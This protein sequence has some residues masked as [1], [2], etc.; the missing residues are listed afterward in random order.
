MS[1]VLR[2]GRGRRGRS[3]VA[4]DRDGGM[5]VIVLASSAHGAGRTM[6]AAHI[7]AE[8]GRAGDGPVAVLDA[9]PRGDLWEWWRRRQGKG[10]APSFAARVADG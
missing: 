5:A 7:A 4:A 2:F 6:L 1:N 9:D 3:E 10:G 8:A